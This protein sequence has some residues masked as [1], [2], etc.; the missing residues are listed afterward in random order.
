MQCFRV[1]ESGHTGFDLLNDQQRFQGA[2]AVAITDDEAIRSAA[3]SL[4][5][6]VPSGR[7]ACFARA[8]V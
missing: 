1:D 4:K 2:A 7:P 3:A 5:Q 8:L 6:T